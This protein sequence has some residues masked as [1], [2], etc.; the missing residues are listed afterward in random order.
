MPCDQRRT[1]SVEWTEKTDMKL[2]ADALRA[3]GYSVQE[4]EGRRLNF[5][6]GGVYGTFENNR[7]NVSENRYS[8]FDDVAQTQL[9]KAYARASVNH[10][11][12][13]NRWPIRW[14][15]EDEFEVVRN[16]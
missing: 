4:H 8:Q 12:K 15:N 9:K 2:L 13:V 10:A 1:V 6:R 16:S 5:Q 3:E 14:V 7:F 11:A